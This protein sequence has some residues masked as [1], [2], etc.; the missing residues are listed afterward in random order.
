[1]LDLKGKKI[2]VVGLGIS[3]FSAARLLSGKGALV[4]VTENDDND[5][6][7]DYAEK[8]SEFAVEI[9]IGGHTED[10]FKFPDMVV[11]SPGVDNGALPLAFAR[12]NDIPVIGELELGWM[13]CASPIIAVTGTNGKTTTTELIGK[14]LLNSGKG[15]VVCGNIGNPLTG[16]IEDL[17]RDKIAVVEV[18]SFQLDTI[19]KFKPYIAVLLNVTDDHYER[20][21]NYENY[22]NSKFRIFL[23]QDENDWAVLNS[24]FRND[25]ALRN[26]RSRKSFFKKEDCADLESVP[27]KGDHNLENIACAVAVA[28][29]MGISKADAY[30][31]IAAFKGLGHRFE[32]IGTFG[33]IEFIDDSKATN[34]DATKRALE[35]VDKKVVLIAGGRDK[36]GDYRSVSSVIKEKVSAMV[37]IGE[38]A[39]RI[40]NAFSDDVNIVV[41]HTMQD[42]VRK[43]SSIAKKGEIVMLSPMCSSFDMFSS[44][45]QRGEVFK[46]SVLSLKR[47]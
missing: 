20:H 8:L 17:A 45:K 10:F 14:I 19:K 2:L 21:E 43:A 47:D 9:E 34:I 32:I 38:A 37:L 41:A 12:K 23:N 29:I 42:A 11:T 25:Q 15:A 18:S 33:G 46:S 40:K 27:L 22:K 28:G 26:I 35:S 7:R 16:E 31:T 6:I 13:F 30:R 5:T 4:K 3:G 36:G 1:M 39:G 44:Y 24:S